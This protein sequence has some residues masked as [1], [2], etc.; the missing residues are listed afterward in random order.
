MSPR[1]STKAGGI[2]LS[3][4][5]W[6]W[7]ANAPHP[8][9]AQ[10]RKPPRRPE[11]PFTT[12]VHAEPRGE[13]E[14]EERILRAR[15]EFE[16]GIDR[17][18][19]WFLRVE[20]RETADLVV[21][22]KALFIEDENRSDSRTSV[23]GAHRHTSEYLVAGQRFYFYAV[24]TLFGNVVELTGSGARKEADAASA[25]VK[26]LDRY[27]KRNYWPLLERGKLW[28]ASRAP[29][30]ELGREWIRQEVMRRAETLGVPVYLA[31]WSDETLVVTLSS[32][33]YRFPFSPNGFN[34]CVRNV[35]CQHLM[36]KQIVDHLEQTLGKK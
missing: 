10:N 33:E 26:E 5:C 13:P 3:F 11:N 2:V 35:E 34:D 29:A 23:M 32:D 18:D 4:V 6:F 16:E 20:D 36:V 19:D 25:L 17:R 15:R 7:A 22:I 30:E 21:E 14:V 12:F 31:D 27:V 28:R 24:V 1:N 8:A 9:Q